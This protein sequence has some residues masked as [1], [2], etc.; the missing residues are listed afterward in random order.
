MTCMA[1]VG[2]QWGDEGKGK[3]VDFLTERADVVA[4]YQG[5]SNAGHTV[6]FQNMS[7]VLHLIPSGILRNKTSIIGNGVVVDPIALLEEI[8]GLQKMG[9]L[10]KKNLKISQSA[11][12]V[13]PYHLLFDQLREKMNGS[14][15]IG[16]TGRGIG[17]SYTDKVS[18]LG[19]RLID[20]SDPLHFKK[21]L[22]AIIPEKNCLLRYFFQ[23]NIELSVE[24]IFKDY[25]NYYEQLRPYLTDTSILINQAIERGQNV[26]FEGAQ[27]TFLDV[28]HGTYP[29]VTSSNTLA[30]GAACGCGVGPMKIS[31]VLGIA[32]AYTTRVGEGPFPSELLNETGEL[33]RTEGI[34]FGATTGRPRRCGWFDAVLVRQSVRLNGITSLAI[35]KLD[36]LDKFE[37]IRI[38]TGYRTPDGQTYAEMPPLAVDNLTPVYEDH[39]GWLCTTQNITEYDKLPPALISYL[40]RVSELVNAPISLISVGALREETI[41]PNPDLIWV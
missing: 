17:P 11:H 9:V 8:E 25:L 7:F 5:G 36:V 22:E 3:L 39:P 23:E 20:M 1:I 19:I 35:T 6:K 10:V 2:T 16:T 21:C 38:A 27:G 4:R 31:K 24:T 28:D 41:V 14:R 15:K 12:V 33:L 34:E 30:G 18:R 37:T 29:F 13:M 26:L 32:K 40:K